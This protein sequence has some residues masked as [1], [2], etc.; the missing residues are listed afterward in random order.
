MPACAVRFRGAPLACPQNRAT[1]R[2][3][4]INATGV[5]YKRNPSACDHAT[6]VAL[7]VVLVIAELPMSQAGPGRHKCAICAYARGRADAF[8]DVAEFTRI[9]AERGA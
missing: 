4:G 2:G 7:Q 9:A 6:D 8:R 3:M 5:I 1:P